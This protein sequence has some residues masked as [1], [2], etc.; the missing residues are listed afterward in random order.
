MA[1]IIA[2][3]SGKGGVGKTTTISNLGAILTEVGK[4]VVVVDGNLTTPNLSLH[5]GIPLYPITLHDVLKG[6]AYITEAMYIHPSGVRIVPASLSIDDM[7]GTDVR[8]VPS[9]LTDLLGN[10]EMILMDT[11][12][13]LGQETI[14]TLEAADELLLVTQ[15]DLPSITD[16]LKTKRVAEEMGTEILGA[17]LNKVRGSKTQLTESEARDM[18]DNIPLLAKIPHDNNVPESINMKR[19]V[20]HHSPDSPASSGFRQL[21]S[22]L[23]G[24][25]IKFKGSNRGFFSKLLGWLRG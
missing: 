6:D 3:A 20:V 8:D 7:E 25:E 16:A 9:T 14:S 11:A 23:I 2:V 10:T 19:P 22:E 4:E 18:L 1:R 13:G 21:A 24:E 12:A 15:P 5:F 17:V